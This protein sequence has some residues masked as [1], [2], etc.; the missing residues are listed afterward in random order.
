[1]HSIDNQEWEKIGKTKSG[2]KFTGKNMKEIYFYGYE[3]TYHGSA[4]EE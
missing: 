2:S 1:M 4:Y 3:R